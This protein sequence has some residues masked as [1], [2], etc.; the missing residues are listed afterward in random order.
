VFVH[1]DRW[2][3]GIARRLLGHAE[4][5]MVQQG[6]GRAQLWT[7]EGSPA[8]RL[9]TAAGWRRDGRREAY[10]PMGLIV[11]AYVKQLGGGAST[12]A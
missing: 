6:Y 1:P 12:R 11:V 10:P 5:A 4:A 3:R 9:Y 7:L 8:E 2:R